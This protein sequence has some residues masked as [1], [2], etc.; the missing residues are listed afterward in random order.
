M[1]LLWQLSASDFKTGWVRQAIGKEK[2]FHN[3]A[4]FSPELLRYIGF[5]YLPDSDFH[6]LFLTRNPLT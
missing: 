4:R 5:Q 1:V 3:A 6:C 2:R